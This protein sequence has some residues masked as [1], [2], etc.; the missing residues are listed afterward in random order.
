[1]DKK[2]KRTLLEIAREAVKAAVSGGS[3]PECTVEDN[4]LRT[5]QGCFVTLKSEG[6]LRGCIGR[7]ISDIPLHRLVRDMA[8]ASAT[9]DP[10][11][12]T[13]RITKDEVDELCIEISVLSPLKKIENPLDLQ[14]GVHG[15]YVKRGPSSGCFLPQVATETGWSK[16]E[17]LSNCCSGKAMLSPEAWKDPQT[18]VYVF[19]AEIISEE[20]TGKSGQQP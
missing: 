11:F 5:K 13:N 14:L 17:F 2:Q 7:F 20:E 9:E 6:L 4:R 8:A 3:L 1:M 18:E 12:F 10:R 15:I 19:T 16:E